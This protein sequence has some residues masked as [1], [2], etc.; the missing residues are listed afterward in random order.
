MAFNDTQSTVWGDFKLECFTKDGLQRV[1]TWKYTLSEFHSEQADRWQLE[2]TKWCARWKMGGA[3][4]NHENLKWSRNF[5]SKY[6]EANFE[7]FTKFLNHENLELYDI[8]H[9][10]MI[11]KADV[12]TKLQ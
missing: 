10:G 9:L 5:F 7:R 2:V 1:V 6:F 4:L 11:K 3:M 8:L 12:G